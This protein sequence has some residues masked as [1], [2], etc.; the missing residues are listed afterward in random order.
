MEGPDVL[1]LE[2]GWCS[3]WMINGAGIVQ[4][5]SQ[6]YFFHPWLGRL[7]PPYGDDSGDELEIDNGYRFYEQCI[8][9]QF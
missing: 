8:A 4:G 1:R 3:I 6:P 5:N 9:R 7:G 2:P